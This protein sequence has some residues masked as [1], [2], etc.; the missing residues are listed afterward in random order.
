M[1]TPLPCTIVLMDQGV[2]TSGCVLEWQA[3]AMPKPW[4]GTVPSSGTL[5]LNNTMARMV[6]ETLFGLIWE[7]H[8]VQPV[9]TLHRGLDLRTAPSGE[10]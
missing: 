3:A 1:L 2:H 4:K 7:S 5:V 6:S 10:R 9:G 8:K